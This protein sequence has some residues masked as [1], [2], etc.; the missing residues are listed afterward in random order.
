MRE[1]LLE[2]CVD[3]LSGLALC[4]RNGID[5]IEIAAALD[6]GGLTPTA[7]LIEAARHV[8]P[9]V[10]AMIR[11]RAGD[12]R[13]TRDEVKAACVEIETVARAGLEGVVLGAAVP[14][15]RLDVDALSEMV[16]AASGLGLT[17]HRVIDTL[18][19]PIRGLDE[20]ME[21]GF[22]TVLTSGGGRKAIEAVSTLATLS[23]RAGDRIRVMAGAGITA[24]QIPR[25]AAAAK[26]SAFHASCTTRVPSAERLVDLG[27]A[28]ETRGVTDIS[29][30]D[31]IVQAMEFLKRQRVAAR[32]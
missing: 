17:L 18:D 11:P 14:G 19:D 22:D 21:L 2:I 9:A 8:T 16:S 25:I 28:S 1:P 15:N 20:A 10:R 27:F 12:F 23:R 7:G 32:S 29:R 6:L 5:R 3:T 13:F 24:P 26:I 30:I 4:D 31:D